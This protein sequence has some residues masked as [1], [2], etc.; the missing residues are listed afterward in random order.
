MHSDRRRVLVLGSLEASQVGKQPRPLYYFSVSAQ[1]RLQ[2]LFLFSPSLTHPP[3]RA[4][5]LQGSM[6][7]VA[8][9]LQLSYQVA[10]AP[11]D[12]KVNKF[13]CQLLADRVVSLAGHL[14]RMQGLGHQGRLEK[15]H[16]VRA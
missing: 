12:V 16:E 10:K 2:A 6:V 1:P 13:K 7:D 8:T 4:A 3:E 11:S 9:I 14:E 15:S 5:L